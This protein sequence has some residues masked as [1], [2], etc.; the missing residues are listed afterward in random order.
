MNSEAKLVHDKRFS[1]LFALTRFRFIFLFFF[2]NSH[3]IN[4]RLI[5]LYDVRTMR[6]LTTL[7]GQNKEVTSIAWNPLFETVF[8]SG[9]MDGTIMYWDVGPLGGEEPAARVPF[10]HDMAIWSMAWHPSGHVLATGSQDRHAKFWS[11]NRPG[12]PMGEEDFEEEEVRGD[13]SEV[14][15]DEIELGNHVGIVIGRKGT[16]IIAMQRS[17]GARMHV[18]QARRTLEIVPKGREYVAIDAFATGINNQ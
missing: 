2:A 16:T 5:K 7:K 3:V 13:E 10:A 14:I 11:R 17:T 18:D 4:R 6:E 8:A 12:D 1:L 9:G 15:V